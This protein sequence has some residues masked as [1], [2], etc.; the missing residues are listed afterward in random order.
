M[1]AAVAGPAVDTTRRRTGAVLLDQVRHTTTALWR[2]RVVVVFTCLLPVVW[3]VVVG[4]LAGDAVLAGG[5]E[6]MQVATPSALAMGVLY[7][8]YPAVAI[9]L[10]AARQHGV[11]ARVRGTPLSASSFVAGRVAG[12]SLFAAA[13]V[14]ATT[15]VAVGGYGVDVVWATVP[16][17][18]AT[19]VVATLSFAALGVAVGLLAP[20]TGAAEAIT[21]GTAVAATF[22]SD[23][24]TIGG[25]L[26]SWLVRVGDVL[27]VA[28]LA[29][30]V[31]DQL[32]AAPGDTGWRP[33]PL[34]LLA[35]WGALGAL[36]AAARLRHGAR[37]GA[38]LPASAVHRAPR[39]PLP[40]AE[41]TS[42][43]TALVDRA[44]A[45]HRPRTWRLVLDQARSADRAARRDPTTL[46]FAVLMPV[47]LY[48]LVVTVQGPATQLPSGLP[49]A[50]SF[51]AGMAAWGAAVVAFVNVP[52]ALAAGVESGWLLRLRGTPLVLW[53]HLAGRAVAALWSVLLL[54]AAVLVTG[55][56]AY[57][58][59]PT[60]AGLVLGALVLVV[61]ALTLAACGLVVASFASG[62]QAVGAVALAVLLP[63]GFVSDVFVTGGPAW[64]STVGAVFPLQHLQHALVAAWA[65]TGAET[66][67]ADLTVLVGYLAVGTAVVLVRSPWR[68]RDDRRSG[69]GAAGGAP[70]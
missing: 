28:G 53:H 17:T 16:A 4:S 22:A 21:I 48:A 52:T 61:G 50:V 11:L 57:D 62:A 23:L 58:V 18:V 30:S 37:R 14:L 15:L 24:F 63:L 47:A 13:S 39:T 69:P 35:A 41:P 26:P 54:T 8:A 60:P 46:V 19:L 31:R 56:L 66:A 34:A 49:V 65:P 7:A 36:V 10:T 38:P 25:R 20:S 70:R 64:M 29:E 55:A 1:T 32:T 40:P 45:R 5:V 3:L 12:G 42:L 68:P 27:P 9:S 2:A 67:W 43:D 51:A 44:V 6:V 33:G 59:R